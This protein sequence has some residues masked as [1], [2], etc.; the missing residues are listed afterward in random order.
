M[1]LTKALKRKVASHAGGSLYR[2]NAPSADCYAFNI[3]RGKTGLDFEGGWDWSSGLVDTDA[4]YLFMLD[5]A[6][7]VKV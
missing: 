5:T 1:R 3:V 6:E 2:M 7:F 4:E